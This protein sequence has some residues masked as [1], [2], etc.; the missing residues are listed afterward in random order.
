MLSIIRN[1]EG[2]ENEAEQ[3]I[4]REESAPEQEI[5]PIEQPQIS[6]EIFLNL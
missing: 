6:R 5:I 1:I 2:E 4:R 3:K